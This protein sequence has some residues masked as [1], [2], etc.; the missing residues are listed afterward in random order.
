MPISFC[1]K[2]LGVVH[3]PRQLAPS[4]LPARNWWGAQRGMERSC[5]F[6]EPPGCGRGRR[7]PSPGAGRSWKAAA[8]SPPKGLSAPGRPRPL[9]R[10]FPRP[11]SYGDAIST[12]IRCNWISSGNPERERPQE[13]GA[14]EG[15]K[16]R[17]RAQRPVLPLKMRHPRL[18]ER[19]DLL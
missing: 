14:R 1:G 19:G 15:E 4:N 3:T 7:V 8:P 18:G 16:L 17:N 10:R 6:R 2:P 9:W 5:E 12:S 13:L 11:I